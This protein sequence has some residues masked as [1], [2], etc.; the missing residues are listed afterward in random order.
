MP[1]VSA[2]VI[3]P[4]LLRRHITGSGFMWIHVAFAVLQRA[5]CP[6][7]RCISVALLSAVDHNYSIFLAVEGFVLCVRRYASDTIFTD[8]AYIYNITLKDV[9]H[10]PLAHGLSNEL[11]QMG[12]RVGTPWLCTVGELHMPNKNTDAIMPVKRT[13]KKNATLGF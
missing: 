12:P 9:L 4:E 5:R 13:V 3:A 8:L 1:S 11:G 10:R 6:N 2:A 7:G